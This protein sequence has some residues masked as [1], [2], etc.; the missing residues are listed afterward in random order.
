[1]V[2]RIF[3]FDIMVSGKNAESLVISKIIRMAKNLEINCNS[4]SA[5]LRIPKKCDIEMNAPISATISEF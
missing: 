2:D 1:M 5:I 3:D 4:V